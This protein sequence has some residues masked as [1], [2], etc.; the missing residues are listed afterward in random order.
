MTGASF[1]HNL[2]SGNIF[3]ILKQLLKNK[4][5]RVFIKGFKA[6]IK[7]QNIFFYPDLMVALP[8]EHQYYSTQPVLIAQ[9]LSESTRKF[10]MIDKFIELGVYFAKSLR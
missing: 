7:E 1:L 9:V 3:F 10:D 8:E 4:N 2:I 5:E 6:F